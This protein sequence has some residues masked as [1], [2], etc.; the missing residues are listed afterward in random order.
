MEGK[1]DGWDV[2]VAGYTTQPMSKVGAQAAAAAREV[3]FGDSLNPLPAAPGT[4]A[5]VMAARVSSTAHSGGFVVPSRVDTAGEWNTSSAEG[6]ANSTLPAVSPVAGVGGSAGGPGKKKRGKRQ[7]GSSQPS[8]SPTPSAGEVTLASIAHL[9]H[10]STQAAASQDKASAAER[11]ARG[12]TLRLSDGTSVPFLVLGKARKGAPLFNLVIVHDFFD[13]LDAWQVLLSKTVDKYPGL[14]VLL[15]N[16]PG[17]AN[18]SWPE[19]AVLNNEFQAAVM[20]QVLLASGRDG[21]NTQPDDDKADGRLK[22]KGDRFVGSIDGP[23]ECEPFA[24]CTADRSAWFFVVGV[25]NGGNI[26][27][28][29]AS[30]Y[31]A[32]FPNMRAVVTVNSFLYMDPQLSAAMHDCANVFACTPASRP[33]LPLYF[34][35]RFLFS[36]SYIKKVSA[37]VALATPA[38]PA[39]G[40]VLYVCRRLALPW[41]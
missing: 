1:P 31:A 2:W 33:D 20:Q 17:Q 21:H 4:A 11:A 40:V 9:G 26:A 15:F 12:R 25:G 6:L 3:E 23:K 41:H 39:Q 28:M 27:T 8:A 38:F 5:G 37:S 29:W 7:V 16:V 13:N 30:D 14:Q 10:S 22:K 32:L 19:N 36:P 18:T 35:S 34:F 24:P